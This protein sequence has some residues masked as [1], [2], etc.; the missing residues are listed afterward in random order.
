[1]TAFLVPFRK[2][3]SLIFK[4]YKVQYNLNQNFNLLS[5]QTSVLPPLCSG[6]SAE[7][8][9]QQGQHHPAPLPC[10]EDMVGSVL[11]FVALH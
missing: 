4:D 10:T 1:M 6:V 3:N 9:R 2:C 5:I 11:R 8:Q 7:T